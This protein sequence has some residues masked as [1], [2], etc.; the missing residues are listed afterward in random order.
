MKKRKIG[1]LILVVFLGVSVWSYK[2]VENDRYFEIV[3]NLDIFAT[4][5]KEVNSYYVDEINPGQ[6]MRTGIDA[7]LNSLDPYT[8]YI[9]EDDIED[10]RTI[11]TGEYGGIGAIVDEKDGVS[12]I[13]MPYEGYPAFKAGLKAGDQIIQINGIDISKRNSEERSRL[14]KGQSKSAITLTIFRPIKNEEFEVT[15]QREKITIDNVP[16]FGMVTNNI[17]YIKLTDFTTEAGNEVKS[18]LKKLKHD[19]AT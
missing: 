16:Y 11:T 14:L 7:M 19:G 12:T 18:A 1:F 8:D 10:Y 15:L 17:G 4:L 5:F 9:P 2:S 13:V 3:K 6:L